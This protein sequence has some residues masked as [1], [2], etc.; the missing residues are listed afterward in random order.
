MPFSGLQASAS[1]SS[2]SKKINTTRTFPIPLA[3]VAS[4]S[5]GYGQVVI[6]WNL[7][8]H[9][10]TMVKNNFSILDRNTGLFTI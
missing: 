3:P 9:F 1:Q 6:F 5:P 7:L 2:K 10:R 8:R 4:L